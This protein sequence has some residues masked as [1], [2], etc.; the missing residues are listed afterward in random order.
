MESN[1]VNVLTSH[2]EDESNITPQPVLFDLIDFIDDSFHLARH[3]G[4]NFLNVRQRNNI[5]P[6]EN[7]GH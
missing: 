7:M 2:N 6:A 4:E 3:A 1:W 5:T